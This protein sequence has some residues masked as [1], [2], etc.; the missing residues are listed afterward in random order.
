MRRT[1]EIIAA[2]TG[3]G[4][5]VWEMMPKHERRRLQMALA[6]EAGKRSEQFARFLARG[7]MVDELAGDHEAASGG[8]DAAY[9]IMTGLH[10]R[11]SA[12]YENLRENV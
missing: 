7:A 11:A 4:W 6:R 9:R 12:W 2:L 8:Y 1:I 5:S 10:T 3:L